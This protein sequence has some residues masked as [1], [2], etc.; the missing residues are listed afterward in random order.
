MFNSVTVS[1]HAP[2]ELRLSIVE[3]SCSAVKV[4]DGKYADWV[5][6]T[7]TRVV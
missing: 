6:L 7:I 3:V 5:T 2:L 1:I 4:L